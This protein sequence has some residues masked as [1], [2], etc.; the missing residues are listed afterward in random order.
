MVPTDVVQDR[1][2]VLFFGGI[3]ALLNCAFTLH[4]LSF[5]LDSILQDLLHQPFHA[6]RTVLLFP[7]VIGFFLGGLLLVL[8]SYLRVFVIRALLQYNGW[9]LTP[10]N[11]LNKVSKIFKSD[12]AFLCLSLRYGTC[13]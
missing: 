6:A 11:P 10:R 1:R 7:A 13:C 8:W 4:S 3:G 5:S 2:R 12:N 9:M